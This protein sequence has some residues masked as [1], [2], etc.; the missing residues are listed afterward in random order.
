MALRLAVPAR[1]LIIGLALM[2]VPWQQARA[3]TR[4]VPG[5][6]PTIQAA[7]DASNNGDVILVAP[8]TYTESP[9]LSGKA[10]TIASH[11]YY[12]S[13]RSNI[14]QTIIDGGGSGWVIRFDSSVGSGAAIIGLTLRHADDGLRTLSKVNF[15]DNIVTN[16]GDGI[17][18]GG[19][20]G[21]VVRGCLFHNN[22]DDAIDL[23]NNSSRPDR[24]EHASGQRRRRH[25]DPPPSVHRTR[26]D[27]T[28]RNNVISGNDEDGI[29]LI[30]Y[31][32][33]TN[34]FL[35]I[36]GNTDREQCDGRA[37]NDVLREHGRE[38]RRARASR[39]GS[40]LV[41]NTFWATTMASPAGTA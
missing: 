13:D 19:G 5:W 41:N 3:V 37:G 16:V 4:T 25:R 39:N 38:L 20:S 1:V 12:T 18:F 29:Q 24:A 26:L 30:G 21:G 35:R 9:I 2:F 11:F 32:S 10:L 28:I 6:Y 17:D 31:Q 15:L 34:R 36:E 7:I 33:T 40:W 27:I 22:S 14:S 8:G 23:D